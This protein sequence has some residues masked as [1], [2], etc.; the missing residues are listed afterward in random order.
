DELGRWFAGG[1]RKTAQAFAWIAPTPASIPG[2]FGEVLVNGRPLAEYFT[3]PMDREAV[4]FPFQVADRLGQF[5]VF[6][7][8]GGGGNTGQA[9]ACQ[10][11]IARALLAADESTRS[12]LG[13]SGVLRADVRMVERKKTGKPKARRSYTWVKR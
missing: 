7:R 6:L 8:V 13:S 1:R 5:N 4:V 12:A 9:E 11:A 3:R 2:M 10:L